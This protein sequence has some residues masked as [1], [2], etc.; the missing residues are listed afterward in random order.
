VATG[1]ELRFESGIAGCSVI[2]ACFAFTVIL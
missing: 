2:M 1:G